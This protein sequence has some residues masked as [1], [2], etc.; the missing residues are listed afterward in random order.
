MSTEL[1]II[2]DKK[3]NFIVAP[4][5][6]G[7]L[8]DITTVDWEPVDGKIVWREAIH[9]WGGG[10]AASRINPRITISGTLANRPSMVYA[11]AAADASNS[12]YFT[13]SP[14]LNSLIPFL[15]PVYFSTV[16]Q[17]KYDV[18]AYGTYSYMGAVPVAGA[19]FIGIRNFNSKAY[20]GGGQF[21]YS[22]DSAYTFSIVKDFG[23][24]KAITDLE[25]FNNEL[26][27][28]MGE[29]EHIWK[30]TAAEAFAQSSDVYAT[31]FGTAENLLWRSR[32]TNLLSSCTDTPNVLTSWVPVA[33][34][35]YE[36]G[37]K[38]YAV[39]DLIEYAGAIA[40]IRP[41]GVFFPDSETKFHNQTP[42][43]A[44]YPDASNGIGSF[45]AKGFLFVPSI[46]GL[47]QVSIGFAPPVGPEL[48]SRPN[49]RFHVRGGI[50]WNGS[51]YVICQDSAAVEET[52]IC[53]MA[54]DAGGLSEN[55]YIYHEWL[56]LGSTASAAALVVFTAPTNPTMI[57]GLGTELRYWKLGRGTG[58]DVDDSNYEFATTYHLDSGD[59][60]PSSDRGIEI[61][62]VGVKI[63]G[64]QPIGATV[65]AQYDIDQSGIFRD[66]VTTQDSAGVAPIAKHG[67]FS[68]TRYAPPNKPGHA[69]SIRVSGTVP[70]GT[71]GVNRPEINE[72]WA[73]GNANP[74]TTD[75]ITVSIYADRSSRIFGL[76]QGRS[77]GSIFALFKSW[78]YNGTIIEA[79]IPDY[80]ESDIVRVRVLDVERKN[81]AVFSQGK[82]QIP[83]D[84]LKVTMR[85]VEYGVT[86]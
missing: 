78:V 35:E 9:P 16:N 76:R 7:K 59:I 85:R 51:V 80:S 21:L 81:V 63:V 34:S 5:P 79:L 38:S 40:A 8:C 56:R 32:G 31:S 42:Q 43:L 66:L 13:S 27:I 39:T 50:E 60:I 62:L 71:F 14:K 12:N 6:T 4:T 10:L 33:G 84:I 25:V 69:L 49:F 30:M 53:K 57:C 72:V 37:D 68:E 54:I 86:F 26:I 2:A 48:S 18:A 46:V 28:A 3:Y 64:K 44:T 58:P 83:S 23:V 20:F 55:P 73:F 61:D 74:D 1:Q 36:A 67:F 19:I 75:I 77:A 47:L 15:A 45:V 82:A 24:G 22:V 70:E 29:T 17:L 52:F 65:K 11:K 41:D